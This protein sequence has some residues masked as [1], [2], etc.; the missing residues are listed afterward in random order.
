MFKK[1]NKI[2]TEQLSKVETPVFRTMIIKMITEL[3]IRMDG[4]RKKL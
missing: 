2:P 3:G 1:E 4:Q